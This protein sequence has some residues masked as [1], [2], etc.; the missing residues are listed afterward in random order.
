MNPVTDGAG[1]GFRKDG[2]THASLVCHRGGLAFS[3]ESP[4]CGFRGRFADKMVKHA[5]MDILVPI[6]WRRDTM[7]GF[8]IYLENEGMRNA[9]HPSSV[10]RLFGVSSL[11]ESV[12]ELRRTVSALQNV[13]ATGLEAAVSAAHASNQ[14]ASNV[15]EL[16]RNLAE[17][18]ASVDDVLQIL[19]KDL[20]TGG[21]AVILEAD[22]SLA[23]DS[24]DHRFPW[25]T[26]NDNTRSPRFRWKCE[27]IFGRKIRMLDMGCAG[28]GLVLDFLLAGHFAIG[29]EGSD[30]SLR[31]QRASW[32]LIPNHLMTCDVSR[33][34][35][36]LDATRQPMRFDLISAWE[37]LEHIREEDLPQLFENVRSHLTPDG[38]FVVSIATSEDGNPD[39]GAVYHVT[40]KDREWWL[41]RCARAGLEPVENLFEPLD[42]PRGSGN[43]RYDW[44][45]M[46]NPELGFHL[47]LRSLRQP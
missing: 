34:F 46:T 42:F 36:I 6:R 19:L 8:P 26:R 14:I 7:G 40:V 11:Q 20:T 29:L 30:Y 12:D 25:G 18:G 39:T 15:S 32:R 27:Q 24:D 10:G 37:V 45:V 44:S 31:S 22:R 9:W 47:V 13:V 28:G 33:P 2:G 1:S 38:L 16:S 41:D 17:L 35:R 4:V 3:R 21:P 5:R 43:G 23:L